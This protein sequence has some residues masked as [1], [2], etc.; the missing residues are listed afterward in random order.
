[1][2]RSFKQ[3]YWRREK[4]REERHKKLWMNYQAKSQA[5]S[6]A[7]TRAKSSDRNCKQG[8][9]ENC[10]RNREQKASKIASKKKSKSKSQPIGVCGACGVVHIIEPSELF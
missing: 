8:K 4:C 2:W 10:E 7:K 6:R 1:M 5:K 3:E 9:T